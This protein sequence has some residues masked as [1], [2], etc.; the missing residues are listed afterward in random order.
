[1]RRQNWLPDLGRVSVFT[2]QNWS[3]PCP[4]SVHL[5]TGVRSKGRDQSSGVCSE[6]WLGEVIEV[7]VVQSL[8]GSIVA[9]YNLLVSQSGY[10]YRETLQ[11]FT[12]T[13]KHYNNGSQ[14]Q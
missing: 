6:V 13:G 3:R 4:V 8:S 2:N 9:K 7:V 5:H 11:Q 10:R 1:M 12:D 14:I